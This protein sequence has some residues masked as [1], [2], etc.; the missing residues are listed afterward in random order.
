MTWAWLTVAVAIGAAAAGLLALLG[1]RAAP[2]RLIREN[3]AGRRVPAVL[4]LAFVGGLLLA[5]PATLAFSG[6]SFRPVEAVTIAAVALVAAAG[7]LDDLLGRGAERGFRGHLGG[8]IRGR[9]TTGVLKLVVGIGSALWLALVIGGGPARVTATT[10][11]VAASAN[12]WNALDVRPGRSAKWGIVALA[13]ALAAAGDA[14]MGLVAGAALGGALGVLPFD[15]AERGMLGDA[16]S[17][18]LGL[19]TGAGLAV[20][21]PTPWLVVAAATALLLQAAAETVTISRV[22]EAVPPLRWFDRLGRRT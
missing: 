15:L 17:N 4:G 14:G 6:G 8:L 9:P 5:A 12:L 19:V 11:L 18:P 3:H 13:A 7:L 16:G 21:L 20:I 1:V 2:A 10:V 22:V